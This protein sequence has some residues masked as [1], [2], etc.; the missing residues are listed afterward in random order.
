[1]HFF[2][3]AKTCLMSEKVTRT[4]NNAIQPKIMNNPLNDV[5]SLMNFDY[6]LARPGTSH[7]TKDQ[8]TAFGNDQWGF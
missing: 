1:M 4:K 6:D 8:S 2:T 5:S 7:G 3:L